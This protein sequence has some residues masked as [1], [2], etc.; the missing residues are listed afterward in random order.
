MS[1][2]QHFLSIPP[3]KAFDV[4]LSTPIKNF[5]KATS[6]DKVD[7]SAA[8][9]GFNA[10]RSDALLRANYRDDCSKLLR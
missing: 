4:P 2:P 6:G 1:N 9:D 5:L 7:H 3:K 10:L 8:I